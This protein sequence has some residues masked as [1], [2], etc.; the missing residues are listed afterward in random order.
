MKAEI[1]FHGKHPDL[2]G[3]FG[4]VDVKLE[5]ETDEE[6]EIF[7]RI[8]ERHCQII[9]NESDEEVIEFGAT[10]TSPEEIKTELIFPKN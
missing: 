3:D 5:P 6:K 1:T 7:S 2:P 10:T 4:W 8:T 9:D